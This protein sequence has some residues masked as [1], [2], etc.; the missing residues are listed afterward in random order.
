MKE[1][2]DTNRYKEIPCLDWKNLY[3]QND[4]TTQGSLQI[5]CNPYK[6]TKDIL[7]RTRTKYFKICVETQKTPNNQSHTEKEKKQKWRN[8]AP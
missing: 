1:I 6:I 3:F 4:C 7:Y 8:Q 2:K 5:Q